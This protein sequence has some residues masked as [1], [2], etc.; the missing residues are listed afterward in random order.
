MSVNELML[1]ENVLVITPEESLKLT[2]FEMLAKEIDPHIEA[3]GTLNGLMI[4]SKVFPGW[5][6]FTEVLSHI[7]FIKDNHHLIKKVAVVTNSEF[8]SVLPRAASHFFRAE[9]KHFCYQDKDVAL[10]WLKSSDT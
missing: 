7:R 3:K 5:D 4:C 6:N 10:D 1:D 9:I 8:L 2:D